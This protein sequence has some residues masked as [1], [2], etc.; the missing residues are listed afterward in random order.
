MDPYS[1]NDDG[2]AK[3]PAAFRAA[4]KADPVKMQALEQEPDVAAIVLGEDVNAFQ[5]LIKSVY[6]VGSRTV[7]FCCILF[8]CAK[9]VS[10]MGTRSKLRVPMPVVRH[11]S[12][13]GA[14]AYSPA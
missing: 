12:R 3:D 11:G 4:L 2:T 8:Q 9:H 7:T 13:H 1:L 10:L 5:E 14:H 6:Q